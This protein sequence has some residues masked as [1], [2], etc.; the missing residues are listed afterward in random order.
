ME[1]AL[2]FQ[3]LCTERTIMKTSYKFPGILQWYEVVD[4][5]TLTLSPVYTAIENI[6]SAT[7]ALQKEIEKCQKNSSMDSIKALSMKL[8]GMISANVNGGIPKYQEVC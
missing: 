1:H 2:S 5:E 7:C 8:Q 4:T 6:R 3:T